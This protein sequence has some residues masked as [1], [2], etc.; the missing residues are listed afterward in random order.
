MSPGRHIVIVCAPEDASFYGH[1]P[2]PG[3]QLM[4]VPFG[5]AICSVLTREVDLILLDCGFE[6]GFGL[7]LLQ[8]FKSRFPGIPVIFVTAQSSEDIVTRAFKSGARD[9]FQKPLPVFA[10]RDLIMKLIGAKRKTA[11]PRD[12]SNAGQQNQTA[13][14]HL[15]QIGRFQ[16]A[17]MKVVCYI[18]SNFSKMIS[19][20]DMAGLANMSKFHFSRLFNREVGMSP[21]RYLKYVRI[22]RAKD[23]LKRA[24]LSVFAVAL[25]VGFEDVSN[26]NKN[27]KNFEG[28]T[29]SQFRSRLHLS[30][31]ST[32]SELG[33]I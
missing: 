29:P 15:C 23:L 5:Q 22:Q 33:E 32:G 24:D 21:V 1:F 27:F 6:A 4:V 9:Y 12:I 18:E 7:Q 17:V 8:D 11:E 20:E 19:L 25:K 16:P 3:E 2:L 14:G 26:F 10:V 30:P 28:C 13:Q 31:H